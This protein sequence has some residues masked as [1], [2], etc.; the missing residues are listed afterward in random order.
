MNKL[1]SMDIK[2]NKKISELRFK[3]QDQ[4]LVRNLFFLFLKQVKSINRLYYIKN[5]RNKRPD[6][7]RPYRN[8]FTI[9]K[10]IRL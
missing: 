7:C 8:E 3:N 6:I 10:F 1:D 5:R 4:L 9:K 2:I